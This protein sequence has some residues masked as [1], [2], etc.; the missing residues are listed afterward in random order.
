MRFIYVD[1]ND[2]TFIQT[3]VSVVNEE[4]KNSHHKDNSHRE[5]KLN[6]VS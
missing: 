6:M 1:Q 2:H 3:N 5:D 4:I